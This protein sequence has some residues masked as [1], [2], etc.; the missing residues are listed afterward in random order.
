MIVVL[1]FVG[2]LFLIAATR[3]EDETKELIE[4]LKSDFTGENNFFVWMLAIGGIYSLGFFKP[5]AKFSSLFVVLI[6]VAVVVRRTD[7]EGN[8]FF[9]S[10]ANQLRDN[11][12]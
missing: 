11:S 6:L 3:G 2:L 9:V 5:L 7:K 4:I 8:T 1:L 10:L 12:E